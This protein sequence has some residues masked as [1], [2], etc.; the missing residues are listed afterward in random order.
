LIDD[1]AVIAQNDFVCTGGSSTS[2][3]LSLSERAGMGALAGILVGI[4]YLAAMIGGIWIIVIAFQ[5]SVLWGL[6]SLLIPLVA[7]VFVI[8]HWEETKKPFLIEIGG[9]VLAV[10]GGA[11][12]GSS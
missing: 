2:F 11:M 7:L 3:N 4:G 12:A 10:A 5:D 1:S 8:Q 9:I 6:G